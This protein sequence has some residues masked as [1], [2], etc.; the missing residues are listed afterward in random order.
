MGT[1][2][3]YELKDDCRQIIDCSF[4]FLLISQCLF[5]WEHLRESIWTERSCHFYKGGILLWRLGYDRIVRRCSLHRMSVHKLRRFPI[6][7]VMRG[8]LSKFY[9]FFPYELLPDLMV[10]QGVHRDWPIA[11]NKTTLS[12]TNSKQPKR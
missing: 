8:K 11:S 4:L 3:F 2:G 12:L 7:L 9:R 10:P 5:R 6:I 1:K